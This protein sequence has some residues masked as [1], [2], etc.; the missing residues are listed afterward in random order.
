MTQKTL[1]RNPT[2]RHHVARTCSVVC[3]PLI[4]V[5]I[6]Q[7]VFVTLHTS[8]PLLVVTGEQQVR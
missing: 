8:A 7:R 1:Q 4:A 2:K 5:R 3:A 6:K